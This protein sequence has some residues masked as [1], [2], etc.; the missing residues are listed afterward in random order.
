MKL[1]FAMPQAGGKAFKEYVSDPAKPVPYG[2][3]QFNR[4][5]TAME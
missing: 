1:G 3:D 5:A 4:W 2:R